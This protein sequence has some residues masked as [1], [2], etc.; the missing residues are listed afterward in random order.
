MKNEFCF[1]T[2][3][4]ELSGAVEDLM[5][6]FCKFIAHQISVAYADQGL[7]FLDENYLMS[8]GL[9]LAFKNL[10]PRLRQ[11]PPPTLI[12]FYSIRVAVSTS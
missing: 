12:H 8:K 9:R 11:D 4:N 1:N 10:Q 3:F 6:F 7:E 2:L 5:R